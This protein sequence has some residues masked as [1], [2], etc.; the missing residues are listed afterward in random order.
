MSKSNG[1]VLWI[2]VSI[3][4]C[5]DKSAYFNVSSEY[6]VRKVRSDYLKAKLEL[7]SNSPIHRL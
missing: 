2:R 7:Q 1:I 6:N 5:H 4:V 3:F